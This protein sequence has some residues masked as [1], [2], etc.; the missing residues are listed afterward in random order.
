MM[1]L[2]LSEEQNNMA[3]YKTLED[4]FSDDF[5]IKYLKEQPKLVEKTQ[6][7]VIQSFLEINKFY[8]ENGREPEQRKIGKERTLFNKLKS[9]RTDKER[10][11]KVKYLDEFNLLGQNDE[12]DF[13]NVKLNNP[14]CESKTVYDMGNLEKNFDNLDAIFDDMDNFGE[15]F[16]E[17]D[18]YDSELE[19][20][21]LDT[22]R[23]A[24]YKQKREQPKDYAVIK[25]LDNFEYYD[26][27]FKNIHSDITSGK[28]ELLPII[29][30]GESSVNIN[31]GDYFIVNGQMLF[32]DNI[33]DQEVVVNKKGK[34]TKNAKMKVI[35]ENGMYHEK[36]RRNS[37]AADF[38]RKQSFK[39]SELINE[40]TGFDKN[41]DIVTGNIYILQSLSSDSK[42]QSIPNF[43]KVGVTKNTV[44]QRISNA[45]N[46]ETYLYSDVAIVTTW[47]VANV[48]AEKL[49]KAIHNVISDYRVDIQIPM[50][51]GRMYKP[52]EWFSI[53]LEK[54]ERVI[55]DIIL[56]LQM[57]VIR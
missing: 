10:S 30:E 7:P 55:N 19:K 24:N 51:N 41:K 15:I 42:I 29:N 33:G 13:L 23:Y 47:Q 14:V 27:M 37:L 6:D 5:F 21:L 35:Y 22:S 34:T 16:L 39:V 56:R 28:R 45:K 4:I 36:L 53:E 48:N 9:Y 57:S 32:V 54:L 50:S 1:N 52:R 18:D 44:E 25:K 20:S 12:N 46:E 11:K 2:E 8:R 17:N 40:N 31:A 26:R 38:R 43:Y 3:D 49:E